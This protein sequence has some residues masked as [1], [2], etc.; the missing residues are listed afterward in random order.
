MCV[1]SLCDVSKL[2]STHCIVA[3]GPSGII[4]GLVKQTC[5]VSKEN[6]LSDKNIYIYI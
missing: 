4:H 6:Y 1:N 5:S 3:H 2:Q